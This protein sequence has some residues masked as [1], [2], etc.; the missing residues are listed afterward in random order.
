MKKS[1]GIDLSKKSPRNLLKRLTDIT[2]STILILILAPFWALVIIAIAADSRGSIIFR[3]RR[4][5]INS[6]Y[7]DMYKFRTMKTGTIDL[8]AE[9]LPD[10]ENKVTRVGKFLRRFS[11]DES[12]Q[13]LNILRGEMSFV[14]PRP[15][16]L[17]QKEQIEIR[18]VLATDKIKPGLTGLAVVNGRDAISI[19][20]KAEFDRVYVYEYRPFMD[21]V[22]ILKTF[23]VVLSFKGGN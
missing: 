22:I 18:K 17:G 9:E 15:S 13:L 23:W 11:I 3:Q 2:F 16:H 19:Q 7:F 12:L 20:E 10:R 4:V 6:G 5:G 21:L 1:S 14:G 8:P